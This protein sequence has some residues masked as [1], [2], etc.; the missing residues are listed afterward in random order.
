MGEAL[1]TGELKG[2]RLELCA[3]GSWTAPHASELET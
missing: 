1:L 3:A 2:E